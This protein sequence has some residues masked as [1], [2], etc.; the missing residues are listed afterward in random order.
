M[1]RREILAA[2]PVAL[3][4]GQ[5]PAG[6]VSPESLRFPP[7]FAFGVASSAYQIEGAVAEDGRGLGMWD[8]YCHTPGR[9][10]GNADIAA[11][12]YHRMPE[13][14]ALIAKAGI[15]NYRFSV[16]WPRLFA[17]DGFTPNQ[18]GFEFYDRLLDELLEHGITPWMTLYHWD[19]P[20]WVAAKGGWTNRDAAYHFED[21]A[22]RTGRHFGDRVAHWM[23]MNESAVQAIMGY[24]Y[25]FHAPGLT[26][27]ANCLSALHHLNLGQGYAIAALR[28]EGVKG[29]VGT[30]G[31]LEPVRPSSDS[32]EDARAA[33][34]FDALWNG[35]ILEPLFKGRYPA[36]VAADFEPHVRAGDLAAINQKIDFIGVN[37]YS[38]LHIQHSQDYDLGAFFG[39]SPD[40][41]KYRA[42]TWPIDP[43]G[44]YEEVKF[45]HQT[46]GAPEI[47][48]SENG[49]ATTSEPR[50]G[51]GL[52]D[53]GRLE[54]LA[55]NLRF[56]SQAAADGMNVSGYFVWALMDSFE[57][58]E[59]TKWH[60]GLVQ[61]EYPDLTRTPRQSYYWYADLIRA[62]GRG[63]KP[64][65]KV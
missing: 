52:E 57:W 16:S 46:Y 51:N 50:P 54:Y 48:I 60:F 47:V 65:V 62:Q 12:H 23:V 44:L 42:L 9:T 31:S 18:R 14:V 4:P 13:D 58:S 24:G 49:Y 15:A 28:G 25:G 29:R 7:G 1:K 5:W 30:V 43:D 55:Q 20:Q 36:L 53:D 8:V 32:P 26:G 33:A 56:L 61:I 17:D 35:A 34:Y 22:A 21:F 11:D 19:L 37:Y 59:G 38:R 41:A 63:L 2:A 39:P 40:K 10:R 3:V 6:L 27:K 64:T 45:I